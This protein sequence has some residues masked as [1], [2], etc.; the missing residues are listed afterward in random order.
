MDREKAFLI[1][2]LEKGRLFVFITQKV[3]AAMG[4]FW[5]PFCPAIE[6]MGIG[7]RGPPIISISP[8]SNRLSAVVSSAIML[9]WIRSKEICWGSQNP[10]FF[11]KMILRRMSDVEENVVQH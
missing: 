10:W 9:I 11:F 1:K 6:S 3:E 2:A 8:F 4:I 5:T 7:L